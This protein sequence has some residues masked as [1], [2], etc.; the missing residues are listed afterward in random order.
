MIRQDAMTDFV[1]PTLAAAA[2]V[3][4]AI[5]AFAGALAMLH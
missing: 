5:L 2:F 3:A 4:S 1:N